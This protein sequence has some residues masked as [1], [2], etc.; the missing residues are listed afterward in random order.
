MTKPLL[1]SNVR[2]CSTPDC[3]RRHYAKDLCF[4][5]YSR[6]R[7]RTSFPVSRRGRRS[8]KLSD[9]GQLCI[10]WRDSAHIPNGAARGR[11]MAFQRDSNF[12]N[13]PG[14]CTVAE[15]ERFIAWFINKG[16]SREYACLVCGANFTSDHQGAKLC[17]DACR[18]VRRIQHVR[19]YQNAHPEKKRDNERRWKAANPD[20]VSEY[21]RRYR[22]ANRDKKRK[23]NRQYYFANRDQIRERK[24]MRRIPIDRE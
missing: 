12:E 17:S 15:F 9:G 21:T 5:C 18:R 8:N 24:R 16:S 23:L 6:E 10:Q 2:I 20:K 1:G 3:G 7:Y 14:K 13:T 19:R 11:W 22:E 4:R